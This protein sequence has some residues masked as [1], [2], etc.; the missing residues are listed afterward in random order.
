MVEDEDGSKYARNKRFLKLDKSTPT[1][2]EADTDNA[3]TE[4]ESEEDEESEVESSIPE[5]DED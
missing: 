2:E 4:Q 5:H 1:G 3:Q